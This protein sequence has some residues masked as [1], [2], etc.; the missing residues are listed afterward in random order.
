[1]GTAARTSSGGPQFPKFVGVFASILVSMHF[2]D[3]A[4]KGWPGTTDPP[5]ISDI[6]P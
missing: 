6:E 3:R 4:K 2:F 1:M 5:S